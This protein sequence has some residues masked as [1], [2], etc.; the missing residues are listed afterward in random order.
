MLTSNNIELYLINSILTKKEDYFLIFEKISPN[1]IFNDLNKKIFLY[2]KEKEQNNQSLEIEIFSVK[3]N[4]EDYILEIKELNNT[5]SVKEII[6]FCI[7]RNKN[8]II[9]KNIKDLNKGFLSSEEKKILISNTLK[10]LDNQEHISTISN[11]KS[12]IDKYKEYLN[13]IIEINK[14]SKDGLIGISTGINSLNEKIKGLKNQD[15]IVVGARP[16]QGKTALTIRFFIEA[17]FANK[18]PVMF[19]LEMQKEQIISRMLTQI[20]N[21]LGMN[22]TMYGEDFDNNK[23]II[24]ELLSFLESKSFFIED[25]IDPNGATKAKITINDLI[26]KTKEIDKTL[27]LEN[28]NEKIGLIIVDY[29]QLLSGDLIRNNMSTNDIMGEISKGVKNLGRM[30]QCPIVV[31]SQ[32]NRDLE[33]R[34]DKRPQM[35]DLRDSGAIE[36]DADIIMFVYRSAVYLEKEIREQLKKK[37]NDPQL[38]RELQI[39][40]NQ[41]VTDAEII[42]GKQ[43]NGPIGIVNAEFFKK[44]S[45][46]GDVNEFVDDVFKQ[47]NEED[48]DIYEED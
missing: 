29:L 44:C 1:Y 27:K 21:E 43:R 3:F 20:N 46:F 25:F 16:S 8:T 17:I 28:P 36:Q 22:N 31:L 30:H 23:V 9:D 7:E 6:N 19:S 34:Q 45:M 39:L 35:S 12:S 32:L 41:I 33:K 5:Y 18:N 47:N 37:P 26:T 13:N 40:E 10:E 4:I 14:T 24:D 38:L 48:L 15:F 2:L 11:S 42:I